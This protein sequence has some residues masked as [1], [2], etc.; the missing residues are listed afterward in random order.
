[1]DVDAL[2]PPMEA[3]EKIIFSIDQQ[4]PQWV[5]NAPAPK[6]FRFE[7]QASIRFKLNLKLT[8]VSYLSRP[9][10][11]K[12]I[13]LEPIQEALRKPYR[14]RTIYIDGGQGVGKSHLLLETV[15][16]LRNDP[17]FRVMYMHD[18]SNLIKK[19]GEEQAEKELRNYIA[20]CLTDDDRSV[21]E[22]ALALGAVPFYLEPF[23]TAVTEHLKSINCELIMIF[24]QHNAVGKRGEGIWSAYPWSIPLEGVAGAITIAS[25]SANNEAGAK[26]P[27]GTRKVPFWSPLD[28][29]EYGV[30]KERMVSGIPDW[31]DD[32][33]RV[34]T[35]G[36]PLF[37]AELLGYVTQRNNNFNEGLLAYERYHI[38]EMSRSYNY[39]LDS[40]ILM[41][42]EHSETAKIMELA[43]VSQTPA[44][45]F[46]PQLMDR[47]FCFRDIESNLILV[48][49][50]L[51]SRMLV[52]NHR[53]NILDSTDSFLA[54]FHTYCQ[55][56][57]PGRELPNSGDIIELGVMN[58]LAKA[59]LPD[60]I[61]IHPIKGGKL[62]EETVPILIKKNLPVKWVEPAGMSLSDK[63][64]FCLGMCPHKSTLYFP[65][66]RS[67]AQVDCFVYVADCNPKILYAGQITKMQINNHRSIEY[68][69]E[70][71]P[72]SWRERDVRLQPLWIGVPFQGT[73]RE[74]APLMEGDLVCDIMKYA[75]LNRELERVLL[76]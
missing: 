20:E 56:L 24:D 73:L 25:A 18:C 10:T 8:T 35:R 34:T 52:E 40:K 61:K 75:S 58:L 69:T 76:L 70:H 5:D 33:A 22:I 72:L 42:Q 63:L 68:K 30:W 27:E 3:M 13:L 23:L 21:E 66:S 45:P 48:H 36:V 47:R 64:V 59:G 28:E 9:K 2:T 50:P 41:S 4:S 67:F 29:V 7:T 1:M 31:N 11:L 38:D 43:I 51:F 6:S 74:T 26:I 39:F 32:A 44:I 57:Y 60:K 65:K 49:H 55:E 19:R 17:C 62:R 71:L 54:A 46:R 12:S 14:L 37:L 53:R 16:R 15:L